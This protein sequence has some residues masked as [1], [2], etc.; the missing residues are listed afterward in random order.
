MG[1][2]DGAISAPIYDETIKETVEQTM[3]GSRSFDSGEDGVEM[4]PVTIAGVWSATTETPDDLDEIF[5]ER[6]SNEK[7]LVSETTDQ[8]TRLLSNPLSHLHSIPWPVRSQPDFSRR[9][10]FAPSLRLPSF[11]RLLPTLLGQ[12]L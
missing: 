5:D 2:T 6:P 9:R 8:Q 10:H 3:F 7:L 11:S 4:V 12:R 1:A